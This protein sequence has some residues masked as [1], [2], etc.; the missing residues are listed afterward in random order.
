MQTL[1]A[2]DIAGNFDF[3]KHVYRDYVNGIDVYDYS[4]TYLQFTIIAMD[5]YSE[6]RC[7]GVHTNT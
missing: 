4:L 3:F 5:G 7:I 1:T 6:N 2:Q